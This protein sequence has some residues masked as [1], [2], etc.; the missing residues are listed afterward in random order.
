MLWRLRSFSGRTRHW[1]KFKN[2]AALAVK[3]RNRARHRAQPRIQAR[4]SPGGRDARSAAVVVDDNVTSVMHR[5][6][7]G[8]DEGQPGKSLVQFTRRG[9][10]FVAQGGD[11]GL[12]F[13]VRLFACLPTK[14]TQHL[15][16]D[17]GEEAI[18]HLGM[19][20]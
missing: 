12:K 18:V 20:A 14:H 16:D 8:F 15:A 3:R 11:L 13:V 19:T 7:P 5:V 1:L 6:L 17:L 4:R 10:E 9:V 2:P